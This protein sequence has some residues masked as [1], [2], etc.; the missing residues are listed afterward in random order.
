MPDYNPGPSS[1]STANLE[2]QLQYVT[3]PNENQ[4]SNLP[5]HTISQPGTSVFTKDLGPAYWNGTI[6]KTYSTAGVFDVSNYPGV[7]LGANQNNAVRTATG[8]A[9]AA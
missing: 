3:R 2:S 6:W 4:F 7:T 1:T 8:T 5:A 9:L